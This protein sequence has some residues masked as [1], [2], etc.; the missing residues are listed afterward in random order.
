MSVIPSVPQSDETLW[1]V[2]AVAAFLNCSRS[3]VYQRA[4]AGIL[5]CFKV[6]AMLRFEPA[7][8]RAYVRGEWQP[9]L[10]PLSAVVR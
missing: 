3:W 8:I 10:A 4:E 6:G 9:S 2:A 5:P 1:T 7:A